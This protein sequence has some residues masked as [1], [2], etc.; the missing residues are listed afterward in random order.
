MDLEFD[1]GEPGRHKGGMSSFMFAPATWSVAM[2]GAWLTAAPLRA[3]D[4]AAAPPK[5]P[6]EAEMMAKMMEYAQPGENHKLLAERAGSWDFKMKM[7]MAP[8][9][10]PTESQGLAVRKA[11]M[12][13][14]YFVTDVTSKFPMPGADGKMHDVD[15]KGMEVEGYDNVKGKF[16]SSWV[17][18]MGTALTLSEGTYDPA[19][20]MFTY[21]FEVEAAPGIKSKERQTVKIEDK[22]HHVYAWYEDRGGKEVKTMEVDYTR[23]K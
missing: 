20:K 8:D 21:N 22:D 11:I 10:P 4:P 15:F 14:R 5:P 2:A 3:Q 19:A 18:N 12:G 7:W 13:G 9:A 23:R 1:D 6:S 16:V 17:D